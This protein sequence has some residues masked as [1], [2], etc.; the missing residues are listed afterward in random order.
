[1]QRAE[2]RNKSPPPTKIAAARCEQLVEMLRQQ[3]E[4]VQRTQQERDQ[5]LAESRERLA[6]TNSKSLKLSEQ[7]KPANRL[8]PV[9]SL[10]SRSTRRR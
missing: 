5:M 10:K 7:F 2:A 3:M 9:C 8:C 6:G 4:Q 1:M